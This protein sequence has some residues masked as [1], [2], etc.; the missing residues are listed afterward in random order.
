MRSAAIAIILL[1]LTSYPAARAQSV[2][3]HV[4]KIIV[5]KQEYDHY[6]PWRKKGVQKVPMNGCVMDGNMIITSSHSLADAVNVEAMKMGDSRKYQAEIRV[7]DYQGGIGILTVNDGNYFRNLASAQLCESQPLVGRHCTVCRWDAEGAFREY[8]AEVISTSLRMYKPNSAVLMHTM[9]TDME[10]GGF[11]EPV[12]FEKRLA[13]LSTGFDTAKKNILA[14]GVDSLRRHM[15]DLNDGVYDG[16]PFFWIEGFPLE[17]DVN[18]REYLG[19]GETDT[20]VY[21]DRIHPLSSGSEQI[22]PGDVILSINNTAIEDTG[23][24]SSPHYEKLNFYGLLYLNHFV[25]DTM[26]MTVFREHRRVP[27]QFRLCSVQNDRMKVPLISYDTPPEYGIVGGCIFQH[28]TVGYM[29]TWGPEWEKNA[30]R[31]ILHAYGNAAMERSGEG[32]RVVI[33]NRVLPT[34]VNSGY[35]D[36]NNL[37]LESLNGRAVKNLSALR[38]AVLESSDRYLKFD[39]TGRTSIVLDRREAAASEE[40]VLRTYQIPSA[41]RIAD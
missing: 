23:L 1:S 14:I 33:L 26:D 29:K 10:A 32:E 11:G 17:S 13:G 9:S 22:R 28:L 18:L 8:R 5:T 20:G 24:Y 16:M 4:V 34:A 37:V 6:S 2:S 21:V 30:D 7:R 35:Q 41:W 15:T 27:L 31:R 3:R 40:Q 36:Q 25:N 12:F 39:F 38:K 19:L